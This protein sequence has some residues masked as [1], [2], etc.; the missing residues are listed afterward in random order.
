VLNKA[1]A[2]ASFAVGW[3]LAGSETKVT[4]ERA[5]AESHPVA[6]GIHRR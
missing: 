2:C 4:V 5:L 3:A 1:S 6:C